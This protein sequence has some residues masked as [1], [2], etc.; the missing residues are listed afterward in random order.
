MRFRNDWIEKAAKTIRR[1]RTVT[2]DP[3]SVIS[4]FFSIVHDREGFC[5]RFP[6]PGETFLHTYKFSLLLCE[7]ML[8]FGLNNDKI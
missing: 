3:P 5:K 2:A 6:D 4:R 7:K 1:K 8:T